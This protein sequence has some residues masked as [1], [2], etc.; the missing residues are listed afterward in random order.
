MSADINAVDFVKVQLN[1]DF[2][3]NAGAIRKAVNAGTRL[4]MLCSPNNPSA[5]SLDAEAILSLTDGFD[6]LVVVDEA[7]IDFSSKPSLTAALKDHPNLVILQTF[8]KAWGLAGLR[9]GIAFA[10]EQII[11][12]LNKI[13]YPYNVNSMTQKLV[14]EALNNVKEKEAWVAE[15]LSER[16]HL[17]ELL[18]SLKMVE[19][20]FPS[21]AN[22]LLIKVPNP[23]EVYS[24]LIDRKIIIRD[25]SKVSMCEGCLRITVGSKEEN[26][27]LC[28][29]LVA[30]EK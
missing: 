8:S 27:A 11:A 25:R 24:Y 15:L 30:Y 9:M 28:D 21:D 12:I 5:N 13:K 14:F 17:V 29:A 19:K 10:S 7:Y 6:G 3:L 16:K 23:R 26:K 20:I 2:S 1:E 4:I 18:S 22:F